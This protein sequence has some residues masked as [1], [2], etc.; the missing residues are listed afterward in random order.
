MLPCTPS[1][2]GSASSVAQSLS[3]HVR[4][5]VRKAQEN[6]SVFLCGS[7]SGVCALLIIIQHHDITGHQMSRALHGMM[8]VTVANLPQERAL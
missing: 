3:A 2:S 1:L 8:I 7:V 6:R 5:I 4:S